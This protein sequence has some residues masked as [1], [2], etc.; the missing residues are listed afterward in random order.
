MQVA[1]GKHNSW[2]DK[3]IKISEGKK[4]LDLSTRLST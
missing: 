3:Y 4:T 1:N 2:K